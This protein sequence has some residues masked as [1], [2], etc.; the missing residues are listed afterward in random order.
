MGGRER[1]G[2]EGGLRKCVKYILYYVV[3]ILNAYLFFNL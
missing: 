1:D 2:S 3:F